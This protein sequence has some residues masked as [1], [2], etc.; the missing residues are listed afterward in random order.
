MEASA[1]RK[2]RTPHHTERGKTS[3]LLSDHLQSITVKSDH[4]HTPDYEN[5]ARTINWS[6]TGQ[7]L[8]F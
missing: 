6:V 3:I 8:S 1:E 4:G 5:K 2:T 7:S